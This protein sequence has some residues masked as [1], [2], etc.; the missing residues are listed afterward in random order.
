MLVWGAFH[1]VAFNRAT[2]SWR[3]LR[4]AVPTG[5]IV[6]TGRE[7]IGWGGGCCGDAQSN[8]AAYD[9]ATGTFRKLARSPL[10]PDQAPIGAWTGR[11]LILFVSGINPADGKPWPA[12][13][14]RAAAYSPATNT[15]HRT[16]PLPVRGGTAVWD[17]HEVLVVGG[18]AS[19]QSALAYDPATNGWR[20]LT[21]LPSR[22]LGA[23]AIWSGKRLLLWGGQTGSST[24]LVEA[25][26]GLAYSPRTDRWSVLPRSPLRARSGSAV[27]WTGRALIIWGGEIGTPAGTS[28]P[29]KFLRDGA[30]FRPTSR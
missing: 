10:A 21:P 13:L 28:I 15:W 25:R 4:R 29:P 26:N 7:A 23:S 1:S 11:E 3:T 14:A 8:G 18:G 5:I 22:R 12:R 19:A 17:G 2:G 16:A 27:V 30:A 24:A 9:P 20:R 6:W